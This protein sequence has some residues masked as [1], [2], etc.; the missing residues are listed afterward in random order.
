MKRRQFTAAA[1]A[2]AV[3]RLS[4]STADIELMT[5]LAVQECNDRD[6]LPPTYKTLL[7]DRAA[8]AGKVELARQQP[9]PRQQRSL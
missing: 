6:L 5:L 7:N 1:L 8:L 4:P 3:N 2:A 9:Q